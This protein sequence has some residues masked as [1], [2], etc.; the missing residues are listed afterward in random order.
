ML[1]FVLKKEFLGKI[2]LC[3]HRIFLEAFI[4]VTVITSGKE[5]WSVSQRRGSQGGSGSGEL[6][7]P[8]GHIWPRSSGRQDGLTGVTGP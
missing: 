6:Q 1:A 5:S 8:R 7:G 2:L 3:M 4:R